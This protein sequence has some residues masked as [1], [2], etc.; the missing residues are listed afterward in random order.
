M[1]GLLDYILSNLDIEN[2]EYKKVKEYLC[3]LREITPQ[4]HTI[5]ERMQLNNYRLRLTNRMINLDCT[6]SQDLDRE[7]AKDRSAIESKKIKYHPL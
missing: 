5:G 2:L 1:P 3:Y 6:A 4:V 7:L